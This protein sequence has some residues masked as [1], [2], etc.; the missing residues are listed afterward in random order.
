MQGQER[1]KIL[2][3]I[4]YKCAFG[5]ED[6]SQNLPSD[7][8]AVALP[9]GERRKNTEYGQS[10]RLGCQAGFTVVRHID[11]PDAYEI[12][13]DS[14]ARQHVRKDGCVCHGPGCKETG[15]PQ[16]APRLSDSV[17]DRVA[18][19]LRRGVRPPEIIK[20]IRKD[21]QQAF[22]IQHKL[23]SLEQAALAMSV[24]PFP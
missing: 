20:Q 9:K 22:M 8:S 14:G 24:R 18:C 16:L 1:T 11:R 5:P 4:V 13:F 23:A 15:L 17:K 19:Q 2:E 7:R 12:R 21:H 6:N 3:R 10:I